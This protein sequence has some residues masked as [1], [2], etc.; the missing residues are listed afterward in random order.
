MKNIIRSVFVVQLLILMSCEQPKTI[1]ED[2]ELEHSTE[3]QIR[4]IEKGDVEIITIDD[5]EYIIFKET[6]G[7]NHGFGYMSH[8]GNCINPIHQLNQKLLLNE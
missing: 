2:T 5:C 4:A 8:K 7:A 1:E 3:N 6:T